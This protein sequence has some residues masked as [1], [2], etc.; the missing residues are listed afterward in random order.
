MDNPKCFHVGVS[1]LET[2]LRSGPLYSGYR[3]NILAQFFFHS[4]TL[5][6]MGMVYFSRVLEIP[7]LSHR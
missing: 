2:E 3:V 1:F 6:V 5:V 4:V 7:P